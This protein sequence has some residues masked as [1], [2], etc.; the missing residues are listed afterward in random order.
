[1]PQILSL[2]PETLSRL[3]AEVPDH[4][5][6]LEALEK[7]ADVL[8]T[9]LQANR[10]FNSETFYRH[11]ARLKL[12]EGQSQ[13]LADGMRRAM[14]DTVQDWWA[15]MQELYR[16]EMSR[17]MALLRE[18]MLDVEDDLRKLHA[19]HVARFDECL[20]SFEQIAADC[21]EKVSTPGSSNV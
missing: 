12:L 17:Q 9:V 14:D 13:R 8:Q 19:P 6:R 20:N 1:M 11:D 16:S 3:A 5:I 18:Q 21:T 4:S 15:R 7:R 2:Q 10:Q